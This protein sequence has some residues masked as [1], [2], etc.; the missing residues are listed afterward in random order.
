M[1]KYFTGTFC[2]FLSCCLLAGCGSTAGKGSS[3][4]CEQTNGT[5]AEEGA[6]PGGKDEAQPDGQGEN[7][8]EVGDGTHT[9][10]EDG[11]L[12][13][14]QGEIQQNSDEGSQPGG[15]GG[16]QQ[17]SDEGTRP[18]GQGEIQQSSDR[19]TRPDGDGETP[20]D[21]QGE[22][23]PDSGDGSPNKDAAGQPGTASA[24][25][26]S[27]NYREKG[28]ISDPH[29]DNNAERCCGILLNREG[30]IEWYTVDAGATA[31]AEK[32]IEAEKTSGVRK[33]SET[34]TIG[35]SPL[36]WKYTLED[37]SSI[38]AVWSREAVSWAE[39]LAGTAQPDRITVIL[40]EDHNYYIW[41]ADEGQL[42]HLVKQTGNS[43]AEIVISDWDKTAER[44]YY[45]IPG[46]VAVLENGN[47]AM[48]QQGKE[49]F[50]YSGGDGRLLDRFPCGW[51]DS[52][53]AVGNELFILDYDSPSILHYDAE[54]LEFL[55]A[56]Q[57]NFRMSV[58][59][60][61]WGDALYA[62]C[63]EG[64]FRAEAGGTGF[65]KIIGA[66]G[67]HFSRD[68]G[69]LQDLFVVGDIFYIVYRE[70]GGSLKKY[71]PGAPEEESA[72]TLTV[73]S[74]ETS[75]LIRDM[76]EAFRLQYPEITVVW[77]T[78]EDLKMS[79]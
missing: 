63:P 49:C 16:I 47:I 5:N 69:N 45:M 35:D 28:I 56:L 71:A 64:I 54:R 17:S 31:E 36:L 39:G 14:E 51:Y 30:K 62:C 21:R 27:K 46:R 66:E 22:N 23:R 53:C 60:D 55:P 79:G 12:P 57:G 13:G 7:R 43:F 40:G 25:E 67:F 2:I 37:D 15:Q 29:I 41:Y 78:G 19:G 34:E 6:K 76:I 48:A 61:H 33:T 42:Y 58:R 18:G 44:D 8:P 70:E 9:G 4:D 26:F 50:L 68:N 52:M 65:Q 32:S 11:N 38:E 73:Y 59:L 1:R 72:G 77:E 10:R 24:S 74:L 3:L 20:S 75:E